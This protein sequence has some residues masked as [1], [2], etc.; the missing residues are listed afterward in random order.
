MA[1]VLDKEK[2]KK[3]LEKSDDRW[4]SSHRGVP[5]YREHLAFTADFIVRNYN[6]MRGHNGKRGTPRSIKGQ[7]QNSKLGKKATDKQSMLGLPKARRRRGAA[8]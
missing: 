3:L 1:F 6:R 7:P 4:F 8:V 2:L 5:N